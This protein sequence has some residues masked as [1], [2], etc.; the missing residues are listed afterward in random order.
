MFEP[1]DLHELS[2]RSGPAFVLRIFFEIV[3]KL[4]RALA[5]THDVNAHVAAY[6]II[7]PPVPPARHTQMKKGTRSINWEAEL[8]KAFQEASLHTDGTQQ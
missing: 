2:K 4:D 1:C 5:P 8:L 7:L 3:Q 6:V